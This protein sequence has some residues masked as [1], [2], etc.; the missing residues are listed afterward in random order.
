MSIFDELHNARTETELFV[1]LCS[2]TRTPTYRPLRA[3][4]ASAQ[5]GDGLALELTIR[6]AVKQRIAP[7]EVHLL[8]VVTHVFTLPANGSLLWQMKDQP[9][10]IGLEAIRARLDQLRDTLD[11]LLLA[12][13]RPTEH[14]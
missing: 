13:H 5:Y 8:W 1:L 6:Q 9:I 10:L 11:Y 12:E 7:N 3:E 4:L 2:L 14:V